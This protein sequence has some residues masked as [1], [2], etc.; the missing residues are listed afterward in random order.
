M[1]TKLTDEQ[2][3]ELAKRAINNM[4]EVPFDWYGPTDACRDL[5]FFWELPEDDRARIVTLARELCG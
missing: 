5:P 4:L 3:R 1:S 2:V